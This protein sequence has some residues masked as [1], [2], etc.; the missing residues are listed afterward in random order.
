M[1]YL[2]K[3]EDEDFTEQD[4][5]NL[6]DERHNYYWIIPTDDRFEDSLKKLHCPK[7]F[8]EYRLRYNHILSKI[9]KYMIINFEGTDNDIKNEDCWGW[10]Y[11]KDIKF[12]ENRGDKYM[13]TIN[14]PDYEFDADKYNL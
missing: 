5:Q 8:I 6:K 4:F 13:G 2:K 1:K 14:I 3:F 10:D 12:H 11:Y 9:D 7:S